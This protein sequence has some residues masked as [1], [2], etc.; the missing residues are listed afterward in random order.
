[1]PEFMDTTIDVSCPAC[2]RPIPVTLR[3]IDQGQTVTYP[4]AHE[5]KLEHS[6]DKF[7]NLQRQIDA[8]KRLFD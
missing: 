2:E 4:E 7:S 6:G 8:F 5:V 1:M 3:Q